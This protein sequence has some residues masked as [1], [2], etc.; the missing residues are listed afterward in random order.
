MSNPWEAAVNFDGDVKEIEKQV[1]F[2]AAI[3]QTRKE[4]VKEIVTDDDPVGGDGL[5]QSVK[6]S[7]RRS[8]E[9]GMSGKDGQFPGADFLE[10]QAK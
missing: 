9:R 3:K 1:D 10:K 7:R 4:E 5:R 6:Q 2:T 8:V